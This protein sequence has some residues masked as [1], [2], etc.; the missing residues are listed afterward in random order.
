VT[1]PTF[2]IHNDAVLKQAMTRRAF[3]KRLAWLGAG[4]STLG[5]A[6]KIEPRWI[7]VARRD[8]PIRN[9]SPAFEGLTIAQVS[10]VHLSSWMT[11]ERFHFVIESINALRPDIV[12]LTG[13]FMTRKLKGHLEVLTEGLST[14][15]PCLDAFAVLG[16]HDHWANAAAVRRAIAKSS[17]QELRNSFH[18]LRR[19][20]EVLH[21]CGLDDAW[22]KRADVSRVL[23]QLPKRGAAILLAHEPDFAD[24][25][26]K[27]HRFAWQLSGHSH[28]GQV[29]LPLFGPLHLPP[30]GQ[31]YHTAQ[32]SIGAMKL[33]VNRGVG[34]V[35]PYVRFD[36]RPEITLFTLRAV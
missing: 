12:A 1:K 8:M 34:M 18:T 27:A 13:D 15:A 31:K 11:R 32:Y 9:L 21:I 33:Y 25:Y 36:C 20:G 14:L 35:W 6:T 29:R 5:W 2:P 28:G 16:N 23:Q 19:G 4:A 22:A 30:F 10:D 17:V 3:L 26:A 24:E 7:E